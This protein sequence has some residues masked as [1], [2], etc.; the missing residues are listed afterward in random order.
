MELINKI[1]NTLSFNKNN[2]RI[3]GTYQEPWFVAKDICNILGLTNPTESLKILKDSW[4]KYENVQTTTSKQ[5]MNII[6]EPAVYKLI[7]RSN[8]PIAQKF[9]EFICEEVLPSLRKEGEYKMQKIFEDKLEEKNL[10]IYNQEKE[11][12]K[13]KRYLNRLDRNKCAIGNSIYIMTHPKFD[14]EFKIG[15]SSNINERSKDPETYAPD[16]Y[17]YIYHRLVKNMKQ[18][19]TILHSIYASVRINRHKEWFTF[20]NIEEIIKEIDGVCDVIEKAH[21]NNEKLREEVIYVDTELKEDLI[22]V[23][24]HAVKNPLLLPIKPCNVCGLNKTLEE[25]NPAK[26]HRDGRENTCAICRRAKVLESAEQ[27][28]LIIP[29]PK[30]KTCNKCNKTQPLDNF[31][32]QSISVDGHRPRCKDCD[33]VEAKERKEKPKEVV[34]EKLCR[35]CGDTKKISEF[36]KNA[37]KKDGYN[38]YCRDCINVKSKKYNAENKEKISEK[39]KAKRM[40][41]KNKPQLSSI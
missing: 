25:F 23:P 6:N 19:E 26:E 18:V 15:F 32:K 37:T 8:K 10:I 27:K 3:L 33:K 34:E 16:H 7:M 31:R 28:R 14:N 24:P 22:V 30:E 5:L 41:L 2:I 21:K 17:E 38:I 13:N 4:R 20:E 39:K 1:D 11:I 35:Q 12:E 9:Q 29:I 40:E 36:N